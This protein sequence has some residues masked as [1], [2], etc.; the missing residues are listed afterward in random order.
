MNRPDSFRVITIALVALLAFVAHGAT[1]LA[2]HEQA[3]PFSGANG[4]V[5]WGG[6]VA[7]SAGMGS[8]DGDAPMAG[9]TFDAAGNFP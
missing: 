6:L 1:S 5:P 4:S 9:L 8:P 2:Q 7:D 3:F